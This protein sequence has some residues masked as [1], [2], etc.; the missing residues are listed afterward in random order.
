MTVP[1]G[2]PPRVLLIHDGNSVD[3][4]IHFLRAAG[5]LATEAHADDAVAQASKVKPDVIVLDFDCDGEIVAALQNNFRTREIPVI[6]LAELAALRTP[7][8]E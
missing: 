5:L 8:E 7:E 3:A 4:Y 2:T 6:A 1:S